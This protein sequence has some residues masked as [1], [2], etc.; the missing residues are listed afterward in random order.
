MLDAQLE[1][2]RGSWGAWTEGR[3]LGRVDRRGIRRGRGV[4]SA[5]SQVAGG[6]HQARAAGGWVGGWKGQSWG[7]GPGPRGREAGGAGPP[8]VRWARG[9]RSDPGMRR[10]G[11]SSSMRVV[12]TPAQ[13][14][15]WGT[16]RSERPSGSVVG[17]E[18]DPKTALSP[19]SVGAHFLPVNIFVSVLQGFSLRTLVSW[20][21]FCFS[22]SAMLFLSRGCLAV[23]VRFC[24]IGAAF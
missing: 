17:G 12:G 2:L 6:A 20:G 4:E 16:V 19:G 15:S 3:V 22:A 8:T 9:P 14:Q 21:L 1:A 11:G 24:L 23:Q 5:G 18:R 13:L 10:P 7:A